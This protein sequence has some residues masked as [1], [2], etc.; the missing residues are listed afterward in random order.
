VRGFRIELGEIEAH[1]RN[2]SAVR[3]AVVTMREADG[4]K[5]LVAYVVCH[6]QQ[7]CTPD[8]LRA[9]LKECVARVHAAGRRSLAGYTPA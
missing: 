7:A 8:E 4:D 2:H 6:R 1:L 9:H 5:R 3:D